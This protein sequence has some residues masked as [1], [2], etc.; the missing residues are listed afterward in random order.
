[1]VEARC[2]PRQPEPGATPVCTTLSPAWRSVLPVSVTTRTTFPS[3]CPLSSVPFSATHTPS[4]PS[5]LP[6]SLNLPSSWH[7][8]DLFTTDL[9]L[10]NALPLGACR[11]RYPSGFSSNVTSFGESYFKYSSWCSR[12]FVTSSFT[13]RFFPSFSLLLSIHH[14]L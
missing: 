2:T 5:T 1:M 9:S 11:A 3:F 14:I 6:S 4:S 12:H 13:F 10:W 7:P 8:W